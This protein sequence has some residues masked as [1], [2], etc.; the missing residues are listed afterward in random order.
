MNLRLIQFLLFITCPLKV[1]GGSE[2]W[3]QRLT[4][5]I[6]SRTVGDYATAI[7]L[8][9]EA[10]HLAE[11]EFGQGDGFYFVSLS[12][13][14]SSYQMSGDLEK[15][16]HIFSRALKEKEALFGTDHPSVAAS[17]FQ[18]GQIHLRKGEREYAESLFNRANDI[19]LAH[20]ESNQMLE[21]LAFSLRDRDRVV[22]LEKRYLFELS[23][24]EMEL[25]EDHPEL[26]PS[27]D[28]LGVLYQFQG[29]YDD[30]IEMFNRVLTIQ[31][32]LLKP[33]VSA[34]Q[35]CV[36]Q[37]FQCYKRA[38]RMEDATMLASKY[39]DLKRASMVYGSD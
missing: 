32:R 18:L 28:N 19:S 37:L 30:A 36:D 12:Q 21:S 15:A 31:E 38:G 13:L 8:S 27:L 7:R 25:G 1:F 16:E 10:L 9:E 34:L 6:S 20:P 22:A 24:Y 29:R 33:D 4:E 3:E 35:R 26:L 2:A 17:L 5:I 23:A 11:Q 39:S 14:G